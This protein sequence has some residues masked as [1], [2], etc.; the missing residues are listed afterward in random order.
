[1][2]VSSTTF[3]YSWELAIINM[4]ADGNLLPFYNPVCNAPIKRVELESLLGK[5]LCKL[6]VV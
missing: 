3:E 1:L 6:L 5:A 2:I 4:E